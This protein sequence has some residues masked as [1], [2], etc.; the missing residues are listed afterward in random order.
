MCVGFDRSGC[1]IGDL[2]IQEEA[3]NDD[4]KLGG[5]EMFELGHGLTICGMDYGLK[6]PA[7]NSAGESLNKSRDCD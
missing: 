7:E 4:G 6:K 5:E 3:I 1:L 2:P